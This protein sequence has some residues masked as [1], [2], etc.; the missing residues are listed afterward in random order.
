MRFAGRLA[1]SIVSVAAGLGLV[2]AGLRAFV[3]S[4]AAGSAARFE[5]DPDLVYRLR[6]ANVV[7]WSSPEF[8]EVSHT[9]ALGLR[10]GEVGVK[11]P[12]EVRVLAIGDSFTYGHGVQDDE[13]YP[14]VV[15]KLLRG[16]GRKVRVLNAGVPGYNT[17]QAYTW[18]LRDGL[19][20]EPD[21][22]L[23]GVHCSDVSDNY[24]SSLYDV[25]GERLVRR[26]AS[27]TRMYRLGSLAG[28]VPAAVRTSRVFDLLVASIEWHDAPSARPAVADLDA[29]SYRKMRLELADLARRA[30]AERAALAV[31]LM[32]CKKAL[33]AAA[34]DP[35]GPLAPALAEAGIPMLAAADAMLR[36]VGDLRPLF[37]RDDP[38]LAPA[39]NRALAAAVADFVEARGL[40]DPPPV[41]AVRA[42]NG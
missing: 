17:D 4:M 15:E 36:A 34:P 5:L 19:A 27:A 12:G 29:W 40:L 1:L 33:A 24:E 22:V 20:L 26:P 9:N 32:P 37:F 11:A 35:Y 10:G 42:P 28:L 21:V 41:M 25:E 6:P 16:R 14:A 38:H 23:A 13:A 31:V 3:P 7:A 18:A 8:T 2:E 30:A 39:G